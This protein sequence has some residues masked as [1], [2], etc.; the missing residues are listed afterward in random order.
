MRT[1]GKS[2]VLSAAFL[3]GAVLSQSADAQYRLPTDAQPLATPPNSSP[4]S[5]VPPPASWY[6]DPYTNGSTT[7]PQS[8]PR[9]TR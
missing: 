7:C 6:Y 5:R 3:V 2:M 9:S 1:P 8:V 4:T